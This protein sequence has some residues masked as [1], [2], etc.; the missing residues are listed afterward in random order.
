MPD[1]HNIHVVVTYVAAE[2]PFEEDAP[3]S[4]TVGQLKDLVLEKFGLK[5]GPGPGGTTVT[6]T[7]YYEKRPLDN[8]NETIGQVAGDK[9]GLKLKLSQQVTQG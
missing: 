3:R 4:Q 5:E 1:E 6:Y 2:K 9:E 7:L 8:L